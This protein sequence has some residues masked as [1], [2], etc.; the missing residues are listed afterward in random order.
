MKIFV[1]YDMISMRINRKMLFQTEETLESSIKAGIFSFYRKEIH[2]HVSDML[3][4][5]GSILIHI[6]SISFGINFHKITKCMQMA[7]NLI[8]QNFLIRI[9]ILHTYNSRTKY[10]IFFAT[11]E[12]NGFISIHVEHLFDTNPFANAKNFELEQCSN[13]L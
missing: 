6:F 5:L 11:E 3:F 2:K 9:A 4:P 13:Y 7:G 1:P 10:V 12:C 8:M